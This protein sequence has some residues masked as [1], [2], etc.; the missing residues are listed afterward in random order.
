M[1]CSNRNVLQIGVVEGLHNGS[2]EERPF[3]RVMIRPA[4]IAVLTGP[5]LRTIYQVMAGPSFNY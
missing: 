1:Y 5:R 4:R 2:K 3:S